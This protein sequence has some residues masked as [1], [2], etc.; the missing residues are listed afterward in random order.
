M[1]ALAACLP[2]DA[3]AE[4]VT[5]DDEPDA[6]GRYAVGVSARRHC[7]P[8]QHFALHASIDVLFVTCKPD[9]TWGQFALSLCNYRQS[10]G[11]NTRKALI[12]P[13]NKRVPFRSLV[14]QPV[15]GPAGTFARSDLYVLPLWLPLA[16]S[17]TAAPP[18][19][20]IDVRNERL[21]KR[22]VLQRPI[23]HGTGGPRRQLPR[24]LCAKF[25][26]AATVCV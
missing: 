8:G 22:T 18:L 16:L 26:F 2:L 17:Y 4:I 13:A 23:T 11:T 14:E 10:G 6:S 19:Y 9:G 24:C 5:Y 20:V 25:F 7:P 15:G 3:R 21:H 12:V 1:C